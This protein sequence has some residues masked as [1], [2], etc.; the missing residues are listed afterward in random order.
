MHKK[1][2]YYKNMKKQPILYIVVPCYNEEACL[3]ET[4]RCLSEKIRELTAKKIIAKNSKII[5]VDDGSKDK[6]WE[7]ILKLDRELV[8]GLKLAHNRG[9]QNALLAGLMYSK[10]LSD[11]V[12]SIDADLQDDIN[13][14]DEMMEKFKEGYEIVYGVRKDRKSDSVFKRNTAQW[15]YKIMKFLGVEIIYNAADYRLMSKRAL[16]E[17]SKYE[18]V[19]LFLRGITPL[20]GFKWSTVEYSRKKRFAGESKYP[21]NKMLSFAWDGIT[22]FSVKPLRLVLIIGIMMSLI[23]VLVLLYALI[24]WFC[25]KT[26]VDGLLSYVL[27]G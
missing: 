24:V 13:A 8:V 7:K 14:I 20:M 15:F 23:S 22:S 5:Y 9:H 2:C 16:D 6:T 25:G 11:V 10:E 17:L 3:P 12:V 1:L 19:N 18:E 26:E 27:F 4:T 21:L